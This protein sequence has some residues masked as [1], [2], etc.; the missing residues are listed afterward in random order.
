[1]LLKSYKYERTCI[2][3]STLVYDPLIVLDSIQ[4]ETFQNVQFDDCVSS[5]LNE[6]LCEYETGILLLTNFSTTTTLTVF[7]AV[8]E[9]IAVQCGGSLDLKKGTANIASASGDGADAPLHWISGSESTIRKD[10]TTHASPLFIA[11]LK[12]NESISILTE[13]GTINI[14]L[15]GWAMIHCGHFLEVFEDKSR[16]PNSLGNGDSSSSA[17]S[18]IPRINRSQLLHISK[19]QTTSNKT[20]SADLQVYTQI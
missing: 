20:S 13:N 14:V 17:S 7:I 8:A 11:E 15:G 2:L 16:R 12:N 6:G 10:D 3:N 19:N 18:A 1:M 4:P 5:T 9:C